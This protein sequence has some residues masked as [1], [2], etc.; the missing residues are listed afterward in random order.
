M[1]FGKREKLLVISIVVVALCTGGLFWYTRR[2]KAT[3]SAT[4]VST[5]TTTAPDAAG[6]APTPNTENTPSTGVQVADVAK[7]DAKTDTKTDTKTSTAKAKIT[8][9]G[10]V[11]R[12]YAL[13][14][15]G[16]NYN[17]DM[18]SSELARAKELGITDV[19]ANV[20][21]ETATNDDFVNLSIENHLTPTL[22][23]ET[24]NP[25][26]LDTDTYQRAYD[27]AFAIASR[28]KGKV[29]YYQMVNEVSGAAIKS[30][31]AGNKTTDY[32]DA[33]YA[34]LT[35]I[36]RG[37]GDAIKKADPAAQ[38]IVTANW[39]GTGIID[40]LVKDNIGFEVIGWNWYSDMG[41]DLT[42]KVN[43]TTLNIPTYLSKYNKKFW[44]VEV[45]R[46][47]GT[48]DGKMQDQADYLNTFV[49]NLIS[50][51]ETDGLFVFTLTDE[52][53]ALDKQ[54]GHMGLV[55]IDK[56]ADNT[57]PLGSNKPAFTTFKDL[58]AK[59]K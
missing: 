31:A 29:P 47:E 49:N 36:L 54:V 20:E 11:V 22:I 1:Q 42:K 17:S 23:L 41:V 2:T 9:W 57:C 28:Y 46:R 6:D 34:K 44:V 37:M 32:D 18:L 4:P 53:G 43:G 14:G 27:Y 40:R 3:S 26:Y 33:K 12:P 5:T 15:G 39:L 48:F 59:Y 55:S 50:H 30:G 13:K 24:I 58:I 21:N 10:V 38:R 8:H 52:C 25:T 19:R 45:N 16:V 7:T 56:K 35:L 51:P